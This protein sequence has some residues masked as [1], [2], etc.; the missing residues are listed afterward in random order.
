MTEAALRLAGAAKTYPTGTVALAPVNFEVG[1]G[2][3]VS[4]VGP[5]GCGKSTLLRLMAGLLAPSHGTVSRGDDI[6]ETSF[7]FQD[8]TLM[9]WADVRTN[10][11]LP[12]T[13]KGKSAETVPETLKRVGLERFAQ[14]YPRELSGGMQMRASI[15]RAI[16]T[17]PQLLLMD[18][19]F[20][21]LDEFTRFR[22][23][24]DLLA[25]WQQNHWTIVFVTHSIREA[26]FLSQRVIVMSPRPGRVVAD[27][28]IDLPD[29]RD[30]ALRGSHAFADQCAKISE[31]LRD[32][33]TEHAA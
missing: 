29:R 8:A 9:P 22:L 26:V 17:S 23:N 2:S 20:A 24:D 32:V 10:V 15:A 1:R 25:L 3:F 19:P 13:L 7:V 6:S 11:A 30:E 5:S 27:L 12:L 28:A 31:L 33:T 21:A 16:V 18:E 4:L 14:S